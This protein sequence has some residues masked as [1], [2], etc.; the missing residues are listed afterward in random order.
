MPDLKLVN[1][2]LD[3][4]ARENKPESAAV[5]PPAYPWGLSVHLD[6]DV[7]EKLGITKLP[8]V[9]DKLML[10]ARVNVTSVSSNSYAGDT[11]KHRSV[12][13][14]IVDL[15]IGPNETSDKPAAQDVL[16]GKA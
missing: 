6:D 5:E 16:Y 4:K 1:M 11:K 8:D 3:P 15:A 12:A 14:Q 2:K 13:L 10:V 7:L 9:D